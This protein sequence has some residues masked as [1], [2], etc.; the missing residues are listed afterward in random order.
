MLIISL[1]YRE[2]NPNTLCGSEDKA[3]LGGRCPIR[4]NVCQEQSSCFMGPGS[5]KYKTGWGLKLHYSWRSLN[6]SV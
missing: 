1:G 2:K 5:V 4:C 3:L 6:I